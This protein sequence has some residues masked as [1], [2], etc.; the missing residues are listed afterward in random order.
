M[1]RCGDTELPKL[2]IT[3]IYIGVWFLTGFKVHRSIRGAQ[4]FSEVFG[5][6]G[7]QL[8]TA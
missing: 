7:T 2:T 8:A 3:E 6:P 4:R 1:Y 5:M